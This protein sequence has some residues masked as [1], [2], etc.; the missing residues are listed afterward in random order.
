LATK[1]RRISGKDLDTLL[2]TLNKLKEVLG[3]LKMPAAAKET[4]LT[5][6]G[7]MVTILLKFCQPVKD[8]GNSDIPPSQGG[9][10]G[11]EPAEPRKK[12][13]RKPGGQKGHKG[14]VRKPEELT[15]PPVMIIPEGCEDQE[16]WE[17]I[18]EKEHFYTDM[19]ITRV[20]RKYVLVTVKNKITNEIRTLQFPPHARYPFQY[21]PEIKKYSVF[22]SVCQF[23]PFK[24]LAAAI[25]GMAGIAICPGSLVNMVKSA[26]KSSV[27]QQ[28][29]MAAL[30]TFKTADCSIHDETGM[31]HKRHIVWVHISTTM[32]FYYFFLHR[33]RGKEGM[34]AAGVLPN[35]KGTV[36]H[37]GWG[38]YMA[39]K[40]LKHG[41]CNVHIVRRLRKVFQMGDNL[42]ADAMRSLLLDTRKE[43][44]ANGGVLP[45]DRQAEIRQ[46]YAKIIKKGF[47]ATGGKK[48]KLEDWQV[49]RRGRVRKTEARN[50]LEMLYEFEDCVLLFM[51]DKNV[52]FSTNAAERALRMLKVKRK[53]SGYFASFEMG[54]LF[55]LARGY[56][57]TCR[58]HGISNWDAICALVDNKAPDF[59]TQRLQDLEQADDD[60]KAAAQTAAA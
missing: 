24:R 25:K 31:R 40:A 37:D 57:E 38:P 56:L 1:A 10:G 18:A 21:G 50:L 34:D 30:L 11:I 46:E 41:F 19:V 42:W 51:T 32:G 17:I 45:L 22:Q 4:V 27:L 6:V 23:E 48:Y 5:L 15:E 58:V 12:G 54:E 20:V 39:Y 36:I 16:L 14:H 8:P 52:P 43:V 47:R 53:I 29:K 9:L 13:N 55:C 2:T 35:A 3:G 49:G 60:Q 28:F 26:L 33:R 59:I 44:N 7:M